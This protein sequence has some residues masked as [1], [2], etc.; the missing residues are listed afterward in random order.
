MTRATLAVAAD[1]ADAMLIAR[2]WKNLLVMLLLLFLLIQIGVFFAV[3]FYDTASVTV[4]A[5]PTVPTATQPS[6]T[7]TRNLAGPVEWLINVTDFLSIICVVVLAVVL[8][9][10]VSIMLVGRLIGVSHVTTAFVW[11]AVLGALLFPW[12]SL[13]NYPVADTAQ[14][15]PA[16]EERLE[17][18]PHFGLPGVLY[19]WPELRHRAHFP[20][21]PLEQSL[22]GWARFV[23]WP[24][25]SI[26]LLMSVH[27]RSG[28]GLR[29]ALGEAEVQVVDN[30]VTPPMGTV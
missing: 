3:R 5:G 29:F 17:V 19:T 14:T 2:R 28:R 16:P 4:T 30:A 21:S 26:L 1:Y 9:L 6:L 10:I 15:S 27:V 18:G 13:W 25:V 23:A 22:L 12:Q 7:K 20:N 8:L 11:C 24:V